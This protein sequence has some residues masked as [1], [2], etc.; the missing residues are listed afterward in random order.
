MTCSCGHG[1]QPE[2][3]EQTEQLDRDGHDPDRVNPLGLGLEDRQAGGAT[4][5]VGEDQPREEKCRKR[6]RELCLR[7]DRQRGGYREQCQHRDDERHAQ[8]RHL[9]E[10]LRD[11]AGM[12]PGAHGGGEHHDDGGQ[13]NRTRY[14][15]S[16]L[17]HGGFSCTD[18][19]A[20]TGA[21][22]G[23]SQAPSPSGR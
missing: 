19:P 17:G 15:C 22:L 23:A 20:L 12:D 8:Q 2:R 6:G 13:G 21:R 7:S 18:G 5:R 9:R 16:V 11:E 3:C 1:C 4:G 10:M 14:V